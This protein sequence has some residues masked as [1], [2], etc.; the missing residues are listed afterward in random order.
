MS[1]EY[2]YCEKK[3]ELRMTWDLATLPILT[4]TA[5]LFDTV[6]ADP[7]LMM[8]LKPIL[9]YSYLE[10]FGSTIKKVQESGFMA[11]NPTSYIHEDDHDRLKKLQQ[12]LKELHN[13]EERVRTIANDSNVSWSGTV[14]NALL[15]SRI[16]GLPFVGSN[17]CIQPPT[18]PN[19]CPLTNDSRPFTVLNRILSIELPELRVSTLD[20]ILD[21][22]ATKGAKDFRQI[23]RDLVSALS[24]ELLN[25]PNDTELI[26]TRW[27]H[28]KND[29]IDVLVNEFKSDISGWTSMKAGLSILLDI[30]GFI[31]GV[32]I[33][34]GTVAAT[35]D[36][37][38]FLSLLDKKKTFK[39][40]GFLSFL[41][42]LR[43]KSTNKG[44]R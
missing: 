9:G 13:T 36:T 3:V 8:G 15:Y 7:L 32:S 38:D 29:A 31:P 28:V 10:L 41:T 1:D 42:D 27:N 17:G 6:V 44:N 40:L 14:E 25:D 24:T 18:L 4:Q 34:T 2:A 12:F 19:Q 33:A 21:I 5:L 37:A 22:R 43:S 30:A 26:I 20:D 11:F 35:K 39:E 23:M 16:G